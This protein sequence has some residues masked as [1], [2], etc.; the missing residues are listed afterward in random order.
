MYPQI[1]SSTRVASTPRHSTVNAVVPAWL[2][3]I[4]VPKQLGRARTAGT[5]QYDDGCQRQT[6]DSQLPPRP[7]HA[8]REDRYG[9][10]H[11]HRSVVSHEAVDATFF[12]ASHLNDPF[13]WI[14]LFAEMFSLSALELCN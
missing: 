3:V 5:E 9:W 7:R 11:C 12:R 1:K 4:V 14:I 10:Y 2:L 8:K 6:G 13:G